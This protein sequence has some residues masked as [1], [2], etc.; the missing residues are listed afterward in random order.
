M[1]DQV[2]LIPYNVYMTEP[3]QLPV[4]EAEDQGGPDFLVQAEVKEQ[5]ARGIVL[6]GQTCSGENVAVT[7]TLVADGI[8]RV[9]LENEESDPARIRLARDFPADECEVTITHSEGYVYLQTPSL[10][11]EVA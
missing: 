8:A 11:I 1:V 4:R 10:R 2:P 3:P 9:L 6:Q 5:H 7:L